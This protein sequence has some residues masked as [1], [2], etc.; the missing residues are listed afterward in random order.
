MGGKEKGILY[1]GMG[2]GYLGV[3][4]FGGM[5]IMNGIRGIGVGGYISRWSY[6]QDEEKE[7]LGSISLDRG[8]GDSVEIGEIEEKENIC[9]EWGYIQGDGEFICGGIKIIKVR[10]LEGIF[11][12]RGS[13]VSIK[14]IDCWGDL[15]YEGGYVDWDMEGY[16]LCRYLENGCGNGSGVM[17]EIFE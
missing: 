7:K 13:D 3:L 17:I 12:C 14:W 10:E 8:N 15:R 9:V 16:K 11:D 2:E 6:R 5:G 4:N 1:K